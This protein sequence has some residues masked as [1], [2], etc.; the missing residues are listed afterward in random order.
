LKRA[1]IHFSFIENTV[2]GIILLSTINDDY[3]IGLVRTAFIGFYLCGIV[4]LIYFKI[5]QSFEEYS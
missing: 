4:F 3:V 1:V 2:A 5:K